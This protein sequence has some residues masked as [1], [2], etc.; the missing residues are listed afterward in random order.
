MNLHRVDLQVFEFNERAIA[1]Y[2]KVGFREEGRL[3]QHMYRDGR[4]WDIIHMGILRHEFMGQ[5]QGTGGR[6]NRASSC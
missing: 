1:S 3:R 4:Y 5:E 6:N 2:R